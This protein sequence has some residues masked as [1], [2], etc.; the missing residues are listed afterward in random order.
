VHGEVALS[1]GERAM[2]RRQFLFRGL[3]AGGTVALPPSLV[4]PF[5]KIFLPAVPR[6]AKGT[7]QMLFPV[8][9]VEYRMEWADSIG[10]W[11]AKVVEPE[12]FR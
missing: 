3:V 1:Q 11:V 5:R 8:V 9:P 4:W 2:D 7:E 10:L 12:V 6:V